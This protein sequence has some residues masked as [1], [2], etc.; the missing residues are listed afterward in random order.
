[1]RYYKFEGLAE[2]LEAHG[3]LYDRRKCNF[4][5]CDLGFGD[6]DG[7][8]FVTG[9]NREDNLRDYVYAHFRQRMPHATALYQPVLEGL[10]VCYGKTWGGVSL[11]EMKARF[12]RALEQRP[13]MDFLEEFRKG[14]G[15][16]VQRH[17]TF[18][19]LGAL[20]VEGLLA[21]DRFE[22]IL[23]LMYCGAD[24]ARFF[25]LLEERL[26]ISER[27]FHDAMLARMRRA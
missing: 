3:L 27:G 6:A 15:A 9:M 21:E 22:D 18:F 12:A 1:M 24:G 11:R 10:A 19:F 16:S 14:R 7:A 5:R 4:L 20:I 8:R 13:D 23:A 2:L 25:A 26:G 17:F